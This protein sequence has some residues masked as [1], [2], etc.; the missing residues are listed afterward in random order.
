MVKETD[1]VNVA[2]QGM[3]TADVRHLFL[4]GDDLGDVTWR[5]RNSRSREG[6][7]S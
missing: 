7:R 3:L 4:R 2:T 6:S 1:T 5:R